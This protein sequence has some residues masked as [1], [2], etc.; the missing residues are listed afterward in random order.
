[1]QIVLKL[2]MPSVAVKGTPMEDTFKIGSRTFNSRL[3]VGTGKYKNL[4]ETDLAIQ[5]SGA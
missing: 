1:M 4:Q 5:A 2:F 3:L